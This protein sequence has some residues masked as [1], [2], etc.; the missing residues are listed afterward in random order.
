MSR[1]H[2]RS[3]LALAGTVLSAGAAG[4]LE[5]I[6]D[7][8]EDLTEPGAGDVD[9]VWDDLVRV[10]PDTEDERVFV[11]AVVK[12]VGDRTLNY[13]EIR[14]TFVDA[15]GAELERVIEHVDEDVSSGEEW[16]F[17]VEFPQF[18]EQAAAV[19]GYE[20]EPVTGV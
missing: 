14:A 20:L 5:F 13:V 18:G 12:N 4:C 10:D 11:W 15:A 1:L 17:E 2:R 6:D 9:I 19:A 3:V 7:D 16:S 8:G